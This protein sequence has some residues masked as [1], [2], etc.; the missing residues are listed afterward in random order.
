VSVWIE[1]DGATAL[2][3]GD[4]MHHPLQFARTDLREGADSDVEQARATRRRMIA[5]VADR[6]I[7]FFGTHFPTSPVGR[8]VGDG[9]D[10][11]RFVP[12]PPHSS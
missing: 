8:V 3:S 2:I 11:Y 1:S 12:V 4:F 7:T 10:A 6:D 5:T 9:D